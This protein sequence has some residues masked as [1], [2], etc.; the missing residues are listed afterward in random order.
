MAI[1]FCSI[2]SVIWGALESR[3]LAQTFPEPI[4]DIGIVQ[5]FGEEKTDRL[6]FDAVGGDRFTQ[7]LFLMCKSIPSR[8]KTAF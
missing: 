8:T 3:V 7:S 4:L 5:R 1:A 2:T 6:V